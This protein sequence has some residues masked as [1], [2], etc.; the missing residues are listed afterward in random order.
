MRTICLYMTL[1]CA[2][3]QLALFSV[4]ADLVM[5]DLRERSPRMLYLE[6]MLVVTTVVVII[7]CSV[8]TSG[9]CLIRPEDEDDAYPCSRCLEDLEEDI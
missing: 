1:L 4:V 8:V 7:V 5:R 9:L 3:L 6:S 2:A